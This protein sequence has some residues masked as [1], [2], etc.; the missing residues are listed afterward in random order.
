[1]VTVGDNPQ[2]QIHPLGHEQVGRGNDGLFVGDVVENLQVTVVQVYGGIPADM[3][4]GNHLQNLAGADPQAGTQTG[5]P[6]E[7]VVVGTHGIQGHQTSHGGTGYDGVF[8][9]GKGA[10]VGVNIGLQGV[11]QPV[12]V[13]TALALDFSQL[14]IL[15]M[16]GG[17]LDQT[18]VSFVVALYTHDDQLLFALFHIGVHSPGLA[19]CGILV[20]EH[21]MTVKHIHD[22]IAFVGFFFI[23]FGK[24][25]IGPAGLV[26]GQLRN[27][28]IPFLYHRL[29]SSSDWL[30][31]SII[32]NIGIVN[33]GK[34]F[35]EKHSTARGG[36]L[37]ILWKM[38]CRFSKV[39]T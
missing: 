37:Q 2:G 36:Q 22:R 8:S 19:V 26:A 23:G 6:L 27:D 1:M 13:E 5:G 14:G 11:Y 30:N 38:G 10:V 17:I 29:V 16:K 31:N 33:T 32:R 18:A 9:V 20:K 28:Y 25:D 4:S 3:G 15:K 34:N 12:H 35:C 39:Q 21:V 24:I 7:D